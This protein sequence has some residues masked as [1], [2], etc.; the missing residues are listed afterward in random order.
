LAW[1]RSVSWPGTV[2]IRRRACTS[3]AG[4]ADA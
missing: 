3:H 4:R 1:K 2:S